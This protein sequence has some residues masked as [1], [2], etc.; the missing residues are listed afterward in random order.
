MK[1]KHFFYLSLLWPICAADFLLVIAL[2]LAFSYL[3]SHLVLLNILVGVSFIWIL[4]YRGSSQTGKVSTGIFAALIYALAWRFVI[5]VLLA[6]VL[7]ID[8]YKIN[9]LELR[10]W[11]FGVLM[12]SFIGTPIVSL[13]TWPTAYLGSKK[14]IKDRELFLPDPKRGQRSWAGIP[15]FFCVRTIV[16]LYVLHIIYGMWV[17][18]AFD[19]SLAAWSLPSCFFQPD[20]SLFLGYLFALLFFNIMLVCADMVLSRKSFSSKAMFVL[21]VLIALPAYLFTGVTQAIIFSLP[22]IT[23]VGIRLMNIRRKELSD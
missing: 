3:Q 6:S 7:G 14:A 10:D 12:L 2:P 8:Y 5:S 13:L 4:S 20:A 9:V 18:E 23:G 19:C 21:D 16:I 15:L 17:H 11:L 1:N 22:V